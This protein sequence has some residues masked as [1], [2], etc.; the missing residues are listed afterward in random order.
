MKIRGHD[1]RGESMGNKNFYLIIPFL[2]LSWSQ[3]I[4]A[5]DPADAFDKKCASC[6]TIGG[7]D[8]VGPDLKEVSKRRD[9]TWLVRFIKE[10]QSMVQEGDPIA[11]ELFNKYRQKKMPD[12]EFSDDEIKQLISFMDSGPTNKVQKFKS[13]LESTDK[14]IAYGKALFEGNIRFANAGPSCLSCHSAGH[15]GI[16]GGGALGPDLT[17]AYSGYGDNGISK[18]LTKVSFPSMA[19]IYAK[20]PLTEQEVFGLKAY[21]YSVDKIGNVNNGTS[22]K[23][24]LAGG[25]G[26]LLLLGVY[27]LSWR[28][29]RK[30]T[31]RPQR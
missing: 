24:L 13:A 27:D 7:G 16:I 4:L 23:F 9:M 19:S 25:I 8:D 11:V 2:A 29:R 26:F 1:F 18:V 17:L 21:L 28:T 6:H 12:Q 14:D 15:A 10:S 3:S 30:K 5:F 22:K 31:K 20:H